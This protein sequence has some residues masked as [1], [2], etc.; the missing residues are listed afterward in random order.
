[1]TVFPVAASNH[2][3]APLT[4]VELFTSQGCS[5]CPPADAFLGELSKRS[6]VL[7][8]SVHVDYWDYIGWKDPFAS[9]KNTERQ[10]R[11]SK[12][13]GMRYIYTPQLVIQGADHEVG[14]D[15]TKILAKIAKAAKLDQVAVGIRRD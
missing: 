9:P 13:L 4:L 7:A 11:Y 10:R 5:S 3:A 6:D 12:F 1:M 2:Q 15:R 14:S 8:L